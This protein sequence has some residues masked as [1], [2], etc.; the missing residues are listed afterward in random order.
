MINGE[1]NHRLKRYRGKAKVEIKT[2][3]QPTEE[4]AQRLIIKLDGR[5]ASVAKSPL[6]VMINKTK[7]SV[8][9]TIQNVYW[10]QSKRR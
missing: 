7:P 10:R 3:K 4:S 5:L 6:G 9:Y 2:S 1:R 8:D